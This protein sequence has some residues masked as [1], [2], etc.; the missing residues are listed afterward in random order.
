MKTVSITCDKCG[1]DITNVDYNTINMRRYY[2]KVPVGNAPSS[3]AR[4]A[5]MQLCDECFAKLVK[6]LKVTPFYTDSNEAED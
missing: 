4:V 5:S 1:A 3:Y 6:Y 2:R